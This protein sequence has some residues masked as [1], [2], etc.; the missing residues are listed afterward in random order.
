MSAGLSGFLPSEI[1][2]ALINIV[3]PAARIMAAGRSYFRWAT[4]RLKVW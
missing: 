2:E 3:S 4:T 1:A